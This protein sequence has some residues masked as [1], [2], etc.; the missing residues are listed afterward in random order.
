VAFRSAAALLSASNSK[1]IRAP[2]S[3]LDPITLNFMPQPSFDELPSPPIVSNS[4]YDIFIWI[5]AGKSASRD[6]WR[7]RRRSDEILNLQL[8]MWLM[9]SPM[10]IV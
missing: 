10:D 3:R 1:D 4:G 6:T 8:G 2:V 7:S 5:I 9:L